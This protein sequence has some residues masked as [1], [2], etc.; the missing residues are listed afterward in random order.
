[1][2]DTTTPT[3]EEQPKQTV[4]KAVVTPKRRYFFPY[5]GVSVEANTLDEAQSAYKKQLKTKEGR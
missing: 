2:T 4:A 5:A 3:V 1:M